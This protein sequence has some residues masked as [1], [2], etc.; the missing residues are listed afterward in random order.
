MSVDAPSAALAPSPAGTEDAEVAH[1][2]CG[3]CFPIGTSHV[4]GACGEGPLCGGVVG[5]DAPR[6]P[7]CRW[8]D[9]L[10]VLPCGH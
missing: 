7:A 10:P 3:F 8:L 5:D 1:L 4:V 6:C 2:V 9:T